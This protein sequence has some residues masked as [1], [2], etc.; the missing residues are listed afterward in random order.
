MRIHDWRL[1]P[2]G[3][4]ENWPQDFVYHPT[5]NPGGHVTGIFV[6]GIDVTERMLQPAST[7]TFSL[8]SA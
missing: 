7:L 5:K 2:I 4:P 3:P 1:S 8:P 6:Q